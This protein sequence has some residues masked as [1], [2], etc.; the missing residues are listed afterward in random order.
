VRRVAA[1]PVLRPLTGVWSLYY[2]AFWLFWSQYPLYATRQ[3]GLTPALFGL[4]VSLVAVGGVLGALATPAVTAR[5][6]A[7]PTL[8]GSVVVGAVGVLLVPLAGGPPAAAAAVLVAGHGLVRLTEQFYAINYTSA[9]QAR[10]PDR[11]QGRVSAAVR[12]L[13]AGAAPVGAL[14]GGL[15]AEAIGLRATA[16]VAGLG[17]VAAT[18]WIALSPVRSLRTLSGEGATPELAAEPAA[19]PDGGSG[20]SGAATSYAT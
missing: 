8:V 1:D 10:T 3:L 17:V 19:E 15:L 14:L 13:T 18:L 5:W 7:G 2:F 11:L 16:V 12:V 20:A 9:I 4:V 6:G